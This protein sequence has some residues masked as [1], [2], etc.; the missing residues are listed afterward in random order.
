MREKKPL[1]L[2]VGRNVKLIREQAGMTQEQLAEILDLG[3]KHF[4]A[5]ERGVAGLSLPV[6]VKLCDA[7]S[8]TAD[9]VLFGCERAED[10]DRALAVQLLTERLQRLPGKQFDA[11][12]KVLDALLAAMDLQQDIK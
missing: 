9:S 3:D 7:L 1:N 10:D 6:L 5:I 2:A 12:Q 11:V 4:S 8:V